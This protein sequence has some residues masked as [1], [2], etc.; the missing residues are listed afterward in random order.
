MNRL[1]CSAFL[2]LMFCSL[3]L[4][5][6]KND[7]PRLLMSFGA[8]NEDVLNAIFNLGGQLAEANFN[9]Q[10][11]ILAV[12]VCSND[13]LPI[14]LAMANSAPFLTTLKLEKRG[15]PKSSIFYLRQ[16]K[17]CKSIPNDYVSTD[18]WLIPKNAEFPEF[19]EARRASNLSGYELTHAGFLAEVDPVEVRSSE[20]EKLTPQSYNLV[21][22]RMVDL[23]RKNKS[24]VAVIQ[25]PYYRR[26][27]TAELNKRVRDTLEY[28]KVN[29]IADH[30]IYVRKMYS[31]NTMASPEDEPK[32][33]DIMVVNED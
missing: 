12:R 15:I 28:L 2:L 14:A 32:Y 3:G 5:Q 24:A 23:M 17:N 25:V 26:S 10:E 21:L 33:P 4:G 20:L 29:N 1:I 27:S 8:N 31:G 30:R 11:E 6:N 13:P 16:N 19:V 9:P 7:R 22:K 18:F